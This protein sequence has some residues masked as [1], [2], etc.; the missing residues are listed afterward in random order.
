VKAL[1]IRQPWA[2]A[3]LHAGKDIE[4]RDW[5]TNFRGHVLI[6][7]G[8]GMTAREY[9]LAL[10]CIADVSPDIELPSYGE[11]RRGGIVGRAVITDCV[12]RSNSPWFQGRYGFVLT[13][14]EL[15]P[16]YPCKGA[17]GFFEVQTPED[18]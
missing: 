9:H 4:N 2:W 11:L 16:F 18:E 7:A 14:V 17:L 3:I 10:A 6:H 13:S 8:K 1:S 12:M 15:L 5:H